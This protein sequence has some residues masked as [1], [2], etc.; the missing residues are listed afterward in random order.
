[1]SDL[2]AIRYNKDVMLEAA[3]F[4]GT[5]RVEQNAALGGSLPSR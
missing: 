1:M 3:L 5:I 4:E 2:R